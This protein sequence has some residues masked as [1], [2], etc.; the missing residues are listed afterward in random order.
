MS[1]MECPYCGAGFD[2]SDDE[3][4]GEDEHDETQCPKCEKYFS[5]TRSYSISYWTNKADCLNGSPHA[6][7]ET[8]RYPRVICGKVQWHCV[9]C[10]KKENRAVS[11]EGNTKDE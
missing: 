5:F 3:P 8:T 9:D 2:Y 10:G 1:D 7:K 11:E 4:R 6:M